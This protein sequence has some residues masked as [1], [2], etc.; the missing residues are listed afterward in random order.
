[1]LRAGPAHQLLQAM[2]HESGSWDPLQ[3]KKDDVEA[4][5]DADED[6]EEPVTPDEDA[7]EETC[8]HFSIWPPTF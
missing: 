5:V 7:T 1:M 4:D 8:V 6:K 2:S 3:P